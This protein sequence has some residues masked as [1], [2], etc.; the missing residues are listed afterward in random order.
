MPG[1]RCG[2]R[3]TGSVVIS[4]VSGEAGGEEGFVVGEVSGVGEGS[5][6]CEGS[7][8]CTDRAVTCFLASLPMSS[9]VLLVEQ[10]IS[11]WL[12]CD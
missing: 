12:A 5:T 7:A 9:A 1:C 11:R 8:G 3:P 10:V 6:A 4:G 2:N